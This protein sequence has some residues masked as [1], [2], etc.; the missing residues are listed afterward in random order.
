MAF[1]HW[2][3]FIPGNEG[4]QAQLGGKPLNCDSSQLSEEFQ[5]QHMVYII[6]N[7]TGILFCV[8]NR[9]RKS[10]ESKRE[11]ERERG[12]GRESRGEREGA[13]ERERERERE[14]KRENILTSFCS[15]SI[16]R[17]VLSPVGVGS[18]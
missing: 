16:A 12:R 1:L 14:R 17:S 13:R 2:L 3:G 10:V 7:N 11:G 4:L 6:M 18:R 5:P 15:R 8:L 9:R